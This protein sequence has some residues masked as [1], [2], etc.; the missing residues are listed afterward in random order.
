MLE[1]L[2]SWSGVA[3]A[4]AEL[5]DDFLRGTARLFAWFTSKEIAPTR[6][7]PPPP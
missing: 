3:H 2:N 7:C 1:C 5:F 6:A 4:G